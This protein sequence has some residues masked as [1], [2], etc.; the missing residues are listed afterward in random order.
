MPVSP[1]PT[2]V[3]VSHEGMSIRP[4]NLDSYMQTEMQNEQPAGIGRA[5]LM[6]LRSS[7]SAKDAIGTKPA[8]Y[9]RVQVQSSDNSDTTTC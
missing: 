5:G 9:Q 3:S 1:V 4:R 6:G 2:S 7:T 8:R